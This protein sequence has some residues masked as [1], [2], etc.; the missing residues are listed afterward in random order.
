MRRNIPSTYSIANFNA[1]LQI[2]QFYWRRTKY[3]VEVLYM[4]VLFKFTF[5]LNL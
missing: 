2:A 5:W 3:V 1:S 4:Y